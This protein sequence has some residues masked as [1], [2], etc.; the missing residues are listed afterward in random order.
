MKN[1]PMLVVGLLLITGC[2]SAANTSQLTS[3]Q[4]GKDVPLGANPSQVIA[5]LETEHIEHSSYR[6]DPIKGRILTAV[7]RDRSNWHIVREDH[8]VDF[9]FDSSDRLTAKTGYNSL[10]GP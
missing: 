7:S 3:L 10:T 5:I 2:K 4:I 1:L 8:V 6:V 9:S